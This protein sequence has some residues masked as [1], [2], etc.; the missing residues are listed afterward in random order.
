MRFS[1]HHFP[2]DTLKIDRSFVASMHRNESSDAIVRAVIALAHSL[3]LRVIAEGVDN[4][5]QLE[6]LQ[7]L[8][9]ESA[10]GFLLSEPL[11]SHGT[12]ELLGLWNDSE[13]GAFAVA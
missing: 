1:L 9:C 8:G 2:G 4:S 13:A 6:T 11:D 5:A 3:D 7:A 10:Q 12:E